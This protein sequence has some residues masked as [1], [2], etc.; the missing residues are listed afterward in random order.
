MESIQ[1][2]IIG[3]E[4]VRHLELPS[5]DAV[6]HAT[7][8]D[9][10]DLA[11]IDAEPYDSAGVLIHDD[12]DPVGTQQCRLAPEQIHTPEAVLHVAEEREPGLASRMRFRPVMNAEDTANHIFVDCNAESQVICWAIRGQPQLGLRRFNSTTA[13]M[14]SLCGP[15]GPGR[16]LR[17]RENNMRYFCLANTWW[18]CSSVDGF[19]TMAERRRRALF[20]KRV[21]KPAMK[22]SAGRRLGARLWPRL[23]TRS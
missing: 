17:L 8:C 22:R 16:R 19:R 9:T 21:H 3:A 4:V 15:F 14:S 11:G 1:G 20:M 6:E 5:D 13:S 12:Q 10:I 2:I 7:E 23:R 18:R